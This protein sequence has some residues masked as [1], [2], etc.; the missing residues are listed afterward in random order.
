ML[1]DPDHSSV[2]VPRRFAQAAIDAVERGPQTSGSPVSELEWA[3]RRRLVAQTTNDAE[4]LGAEVAE[5]AART[6]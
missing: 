6:T 1:T 3:N 2:T 4:M 5:P